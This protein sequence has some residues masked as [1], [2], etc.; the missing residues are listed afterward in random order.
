MRTR[1]V[2]LAAVLGVGV[3]GVGVPA[4]PALADKPERLPMETEP[5]TFEGLCGGSITITELKNNAKQNFEGD[6]F[7]F[8]ERVRGNIVARIDSGDRSVVVRLPGLA[9]ITADEDSFTFLGTGRT[10]FIPVAEEQFESQRR[11]GLPD[12]ALVIGRVEATTTFD[13]ST[14]EAVEEITYNGK[15]V[16]VCDLLE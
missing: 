9:R 10:L 2:T 14:G 16:D 7:G 5:M 8:E 15:V 4:S 3:L 11:A 12:L 6:E 1:L 13:P